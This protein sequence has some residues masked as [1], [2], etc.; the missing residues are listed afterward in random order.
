MSK[1][2]VCLSCHSSKIKARYLQQM[3]PQGQPQLTDTQY[4]RLLSYYLQPYIILIYNTSLVSED[5]PDFQPNILIE[6]FFVLPCKSKN[7]FAVPFLNF[8]YFLI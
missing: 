1:I 8:M 3:C 5:T 6:L 2:K 7:N 4:K